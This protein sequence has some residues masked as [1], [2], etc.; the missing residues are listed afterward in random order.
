MTQYIKITSC[1]DRHLWYHPYIGDL[2]LL[3]KEEED[4]YWTRQ[5]EGFKNIVY[6]TDAERIEYEPRTNG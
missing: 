6:K 3:I 1:R 2:F 5:P 4:L